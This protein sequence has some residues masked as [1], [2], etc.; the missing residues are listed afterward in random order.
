MRKEAATATA[1]EGE[2]FL[3]GAQ[4]SDNDSDNDSDSD[5]ERQRTRGDGWSGALWSYRPSCKS[6]AA[7][8]RSD[9]PA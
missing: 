4:G 8:E 1:E 7:V 5:S 3:G 2:L 9:G 6:R